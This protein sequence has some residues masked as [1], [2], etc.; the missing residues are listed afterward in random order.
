M[1]PGASVRSVV[2]TIYMRAFV[3][4][5]VIASSTACG[6]R[7][8]D[9]CERAATRLARIEERAT[10]GSPFVISDAVFEGC[11]RGGTSLHDPVLRCAL[12]SVSDGA[13]A[14]CIDNFVRAVLTPS[15]DDDG[16]R[17]LNPLLAR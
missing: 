12:D 14:V 16:G 7:A 13:A 9:D 6:E 4:V 8:P 17:G 11:R 5:V 3:L 2:R 10:P 1:M 15:P